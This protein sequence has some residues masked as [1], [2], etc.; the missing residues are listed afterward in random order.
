MK[1]V[2]RAATAAPSRWLHV[3]FIRRAAFPCQASLMVPDPA[4]KRRWVISFLVTG[5]EEGVM[6]VSAEN[7]MKSALWEN[8]EGA[9][10]IT[11]T[12]G[13]F[14]DLDPVEQD[15]WESILRREADDFR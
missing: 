14:G 7:R 1:G 3:W 11:S 4:A 2:A 13:R 5:D 12:V 9:E 8:P 15:R 6:A 10:H